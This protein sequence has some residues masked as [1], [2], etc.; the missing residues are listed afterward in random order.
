[1]RPLP[2]S[3]PLG[4]TGREAG[5]RDGPQTQKSPGPKT[6]PGLPGK[7]IG[8]MQSKWHLRISGVRKYEGFFRQVPSGQPGRVLK[9]PS[10]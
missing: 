3:A 8:F 1:M 9:S 4:Q 6:I 5:T 10:A 7:G 2:D